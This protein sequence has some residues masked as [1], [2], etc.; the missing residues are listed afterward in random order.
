MYIALKETDLF[1]SFI[2]LNLHLMQQ[3]MTV[4]SLHLSAT[5]CYIPYLPWCQCVAYRKGKGPVS[6]HV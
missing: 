1:H 3:L 2:N 4:T 6:N 5:Q